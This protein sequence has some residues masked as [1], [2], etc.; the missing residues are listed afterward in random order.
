MV[1]EPAE[2]PEAASRSD[3]AIEPIAL[4]VETVV[5]VGVGLI[6]ASVGLALR[7]RW[8]GVSVVGV[9]RSEQTRRD[10]VSSGAV[11]RCASVLGDALDGLDA[12]RTAVVVAVPVGSVVRVL[13]ELR[14]WGGLVTDAGSSKAEIVAAARDL[15]WFVGAHPMAGGEQ[16][17][18]LAGKPDLFV[19]RPCVV[20]PHAGNGPEAVGGARALWEA[21]GCR[22][23]EMS[24]EEHD[25]AVAAVSH[26]P[27]A[28][29]C[30][31]ISVV[32]ELGG[33]PVA[34]TGLRDTTRVASSN[35]PMRAD[36]M[37][38]NRGPLLEALREYRG[39]LDELIGDL[40]A[41]DHASLLAGLEKIKATRDGWLDGV[42]E[43]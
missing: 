10:A 20:T 35:P 3:P 2:N 24:A 12:S 27:H 43:L 11:E 34:S 7:A 28:A 29:A 32:R 13:E 5:V 40:E 22:V 8:P 33:W 36:I 37:I 31:L 41:G 26:L 21:V 14:G 9:G 38:S 6:G 17:G 25:R 39:H 15:P 23:V 19:G 16:K 18:P 1:L 42:K 30:L 4:P